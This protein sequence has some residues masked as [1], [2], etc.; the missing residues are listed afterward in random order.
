MEKEEKLRN[1]TDK[2]LCETFES[3]QAVMKER[4]LEQYLCLRV[5]TENGLFMANV[6][7]EKDYPGIDVEFVPDTM[8]EDDMSN[9]RIVMEMA[10]NGTENEK[11]RTLIWTD[12][13]KEDYT[14]EI[15]FEQ[16]EKE[17]E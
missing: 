8:S 14:K 15:V 7:M 2:E 4:N 6:N 13:T 17:G 12:K 16:N 1:L 9:P 5:S 3:L 10:E 11:L